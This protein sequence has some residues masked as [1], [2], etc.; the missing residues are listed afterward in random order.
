MSIWERSKLACNTEK[1]R[2]RSELLTGVFNQSSF[3]ISIVILNNKDYIL[4]SE[5]RR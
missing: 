1:N 4:F 2:K 3:Y 5:A